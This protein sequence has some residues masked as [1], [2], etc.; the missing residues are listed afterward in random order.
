MLRH[1]GRRH[2]TQLL[3]SARGCQSTGDGEQRG[4]TDDRHDGEEGALDIAAELRPAPVAASLGQ[5]FVL[6]HVYSC[7]NGNTKNTPH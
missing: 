5:R 4:E 7:H 3:G 2:V 1:L 6:R